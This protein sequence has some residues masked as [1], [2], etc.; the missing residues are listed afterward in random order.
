MKMIGERVLLSAFWEKAPE[1][2]QNV[3]RSNRIERMKMSL[4]NR[5]R[6][7]IKSGVRTANSYCQ[8]IFAVGFKQRKGIPRALCYA[9]RGRSTI[10]HLCI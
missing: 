8:N 2:W 10:Q 9:K 1:A 4:I 6:K 3:N 7:S 5:I